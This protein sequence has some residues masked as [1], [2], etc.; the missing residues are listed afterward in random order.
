[1]AKRRSPKTVETATWIRRICSRN[2][3]CSES[4]QRS[5]SHH[6]EVGGRTVGRFDQQQVVPRLSCVAG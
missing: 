3:N 5:R 4:D 1:M 2:R 6:V